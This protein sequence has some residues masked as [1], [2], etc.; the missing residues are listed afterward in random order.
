MDSGLEFGW[1]S[2]GL[3][4]LPGPEPLGALLPAEP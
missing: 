4:A 3:A 1:Q 2:R